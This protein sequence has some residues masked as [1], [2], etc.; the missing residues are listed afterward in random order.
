MVHW[1]STRHQP[2]PIPPLANEASP[3]P[4]LPPVLP[5]AKATF[6]GEDSITPDA[7]LTLRQPLS[8]NSNPP[9]SRPPDLRPKGRGQQVFH[10][11]TGADNNMWLIDAS[12]RI[13][14]FFF[15]TCGTCGHQV[16]TRTYVY[17]STQNLTWNSNVPKKM[18]QQTPPDRIMPP[19]LTQ[20]APSFIPTR[21]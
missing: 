12:A 11:H 5:P 19:A 6:F 18:K 8:G 7:T 16:Y 1:R 14:W 17:C 15:G 10:L 3:P 2:P 9:P 13:C 20:F 21:F 4:P